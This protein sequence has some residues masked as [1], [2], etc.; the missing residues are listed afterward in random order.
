MKETKK[1]QMLLLGVVVMALCVLAMPGMASAKVKVKKVTVKSNYGSSVHV[2]VGKKIKLTTTV[3][4]TPNKAANR[5]V[6]YQS[7]N[8]KIATVTSL[9]YV[10]GVKK[11]SCKITVKSKKNKKKKA[12][13]K[14]KVIKKVTSVTIAEP[15]NPL[16]VGNSV[17][18]QATVK[19]GSGSYKKV[20]WS[21]SN[22]S[23]ATVSST[24]KVT[25]K[26]AG[27]V[28]IKATSVEG[29]KKT[30][31]LKLTVL[32]TNS[33]SIASVEVLSSNAVRIV[34]DKAYQLK[35]T[36]IALA[37]KKYS[38]GS[39]VRKYDISQL[40]N[41]DNT[42]YDVT[43]KEDASIVADTFLRVTI[44]DLPGNG[45][46]VMESQAIMLKDTQ[47]QEEKWIGS[48]GDSWDKTVDLSAY[49]CGNITYE[50]IGSIPGI[51]TKI[52]NNQIRFSGTLSTTLTSNV[53][54]IK[55]TD[56]V[57]NTVI[58][59]IYLYVGD[60]NAVVSGAENVTIVMGTDV[61]EKT[62]IQACGGSGN[63]SFTAINLPS[64]IRLDA[65]N[66][67]L[68]GKATK[69]GEYS[70]Q[71][72]VT[73]EENPSLFFKSTVVI[74]VVEQRKVIGTV[75]DEKGQVVPG[76][77]ITCENLTNGSLVT[78]RTKEDGSYTVLVGEG[79]YNITAQSEEKKD[80]VYRIAVGAGGRQIH[81]LLL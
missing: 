29:T 56:E 36:Q 35:E 60:D 49:C 12:T 42:T 17:T 30:G 39:Y 64:G 38:F 47:P 34:L 81:F 68:S 43:I 32:S 31:T 18:L 25:G 62:F 73:D 54:T 11:G 41:Y 6:T 69:L 76:A 66:G 71:F 50:V 58:K 55:A 23:I 67:T 63:Y 70:V 10:K 48:V 26:K 61:T 57:G 77:V 72:V 46:K 65:K 16:Y 22:K 24:G 21:S 59:S 45:T 4:V 15:K 8:K 51:T 9:G 78:T 13:I 2:A 74:S 44:S 20:T 1:K 75:V 19:P 27:T 40:R 5:K 14:V 80:G 37:G 3:K 33:V 28:T 79:T 53:L 52:K 7:S